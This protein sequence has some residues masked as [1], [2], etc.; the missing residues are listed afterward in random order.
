MP[1]ITFIYR[2]ENTEK[3]FYGKY[4]CDDIPNNDEGLDMEIKPTIINGINEYRNK[5]GLAK[6][7]KKVCLGILSFSS[8][9]YTYIYSSVEEINFFDFYYIHCYGVSETYI[10][11]QFII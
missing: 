5:K 9:R 6:L 2:I 7:D 11:G 8:D 3:T 10:N 4:I 1:F